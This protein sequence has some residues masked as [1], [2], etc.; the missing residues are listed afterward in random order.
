MSQ[1]SEFEYSEQ[2]R[3]EGQAINADPREQSGW[4]ET[5]NQ[6]YQADY[7]AARPMGGQKIYPPQRPRRRRRW[8]WALVIIVVIVALLGGFSGLSNTVFSRT[9]ILPQRTFSVSAEPQLVIKD[10]AGTVTIHTGSS[11]RVQV[12]A[13]E[14]TGL[15][16]N[17]ND[18][19]YTVQQTGNTIEVD[20]D[21]SGASFLSGSVDLSITLPSVS[22]IQATINA[23]SMDIDG[24]SGLINVQDNAG[25][26]NFED[27]TIKDGSSFQD[28]AGSITFDGSLASSGG[29]YEFNTNA[30]S[31]DITL[32]ADSSFTLDATTDAG[33]VSN[34][35][36]SNTVGSNP[37]NTQLHAHTDAGSVSVHRK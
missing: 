19:Q 12:S 1:Q 37:T 25:S 10:S 11:N 17:S 3:R 27:G 2:A 30:G 26:I 22:D 33:S 31:I 8:L 6:P 15:F 24:V 32:P 20:V 5:Q 9:T 13:T 34:D 36:G 18:V 21:Q 16:S 35:F 7:V 4:S 29:T 14:H 28:N 23:G